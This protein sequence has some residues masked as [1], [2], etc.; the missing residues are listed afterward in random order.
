MG[1]KTITT[2]ITTQYESR[3]Y[4]SDASAWHRIG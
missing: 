2:T 3:T 1:N 4:Q